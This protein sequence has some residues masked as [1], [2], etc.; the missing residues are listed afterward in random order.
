MAD[1]RHLQAFE[2]YAA[3]TSQRSYRHVADQ[4][5][6]SERTVRHWAKQ[7]KWRGRLREREVLA[8]R[9]AADESVHRGQEET[10]RHLKIVRVALM[11]LTRSIA[12]GNLKQLGELSGL[13]RLEEHL[14]GIAAPGESAGAHIC[15]PVVIL[16]DD[17]SD[18]DFTRLL[19]LSRGSGDP[20]AKWAEPVGSDILRPE[21]ELNAG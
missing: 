6:V 12:A 4:L 3:S 16:P 21:V 5:G 10:Q 17:G 2:L 1:D 14:M 7:G 20:D 9:Q 15:N 18:P 19:A 8:A 13:I 11:F